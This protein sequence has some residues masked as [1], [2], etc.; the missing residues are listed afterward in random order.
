MIVVW[1]VWLRVR[2]LT[3]VLAA[4]IESTAVTFGVSTFV[5]P[6]TLLTWHFV[7]NAV[8]PGIS[9]AATTVLVVSLL[10]VGLVF[11]TVLW[12]VGSNPGTLRCLLTRLAE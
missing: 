5:F 8:A 10:L 9:L 4:T 12:I 11:V 6:V 2:V 3:I 7:L 1:N